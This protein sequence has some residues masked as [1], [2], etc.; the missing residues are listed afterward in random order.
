MAIAG[1]KDIFIVHTKGDHAQRLI[2]ED[3]V[4]RLQ[5]HGLGVWL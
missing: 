2:A 3:L 1:R 5:T 4:R